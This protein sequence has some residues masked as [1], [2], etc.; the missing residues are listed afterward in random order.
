MTHHIYLDL[1]GRPSKES[2]LQLSD[3]ATDQKEKEK[4][5]FLTTP[6]GQA[7]Y[8]ARVDNTVCT[9]N[10]LIS[11]G[12]SNIA[13]QVTFEDVLRDFPSAHPSL[14]KLLEI[15][16]PIKPRHYSIASS[17]KMHPNSVHLLVVLVSW[18]TGAKKSRFGHC[19]RYLSGLAPGDIAIGNPF[20]TTRIHPLS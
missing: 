9:H 6:D 18:E 3:C 1:Y 11:S 4:L 2:Y 12:R 13:L 14:E 16:P 15:I 17:M 5:I 8:K 20:L 7:E 19:T 10:H